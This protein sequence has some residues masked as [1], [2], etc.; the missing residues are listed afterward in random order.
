[1]AQV[2]ASKKVNRKNFRCCVLSA[3]FFSVGLL[4]TGCGTL[5]EVAA[6]AQ[7]R[8]LGAER[9][10]NLT[11]VDVAKANTGKLGSEPEYTGTTSP[12]RQVSLRS[13]VEG[14]VLALSVDVGD[15][16][17]RGQVL[18]QLDDDLLVTA[19]R[20]AEAELA[21]LRSEVARA[22]TLVSN[23]RAQVERSRL[24]LKQAQADSGRQ[25]I[26]LREGAIGAQQAEQAQT[27]AQTAAQALRAAE[28]QVRTEQQAVAA[29]KGRVI[30][31]QAVVAQGR[32]RLSYAKLKSPITG[33]VLEQVTEAGNLVQPGG[34]V[35]KLGDFSQVEVVV[36]VSELELA[37][38]RL[39]Q[40]VKVRLDAFPNQTFSGQVSRISPAADS[41]ARLVPMEVIIPNSEGKIGSGLLARV[42]F[43]GRATQRVVVPQTAISQPKEQQNRQGTVFVV[44]GKEGG[45][46]A[47]VTARP[48][49]LGER[50]D[51]KVEILSGLRAGEQFVARSGKALKDG[52]TVSLSI[53][54]EKPLD[55]GGQQ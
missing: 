16:V 49:T 34:A 53:L 20:Q 22:Q 36:Q 23:A 14:Q 32:K 37:K 5:P 15:A 13:Q 4:V 24:E 6:D 21:T 48:V 46:Q 45:T 27:T 52:E 40:L 35:L 41:T 10:Q 8:P 50:A 26:L 9:R 28:E 3:F 42:S 43:E 19:L 55:L 51:G 44:T 1:M 18:A 33:V 47:K 25:T 11:P 54:S 39:G 38:I 17:K 31:Q 30:A 2:K 7:S 29:A 12:V